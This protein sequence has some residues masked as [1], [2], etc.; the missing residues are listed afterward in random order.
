MSNSKDEDLFISKTQ[1]KQASADRQK[2]GEAIVNLTPAHL[3]TIPMDEELSEAIELARRINRKKDGF[4]RQLQFIGKLL[5][6]RDVAPLEEA[7]NKLKFAHNQANS[8]FHKLEKLRDAIV[9]GG[10]DAIQNTLE[11]YPHLSRQTLRQHQRQI[12]KEKEKNAPPKHYRALFQ[13]LK[14]EI[15]ENN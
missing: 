10:D 7:L 11:D 5:R 12:L 4:R 9:A 3:A 13:Y 15:H 6:T 1:L 8:H 2:I 14:D